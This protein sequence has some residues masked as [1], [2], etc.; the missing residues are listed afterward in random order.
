MKQLLA[1]SL[2]IASAL[3]PLGCATSKPAAGG[4]A[5]TGTISTREKIALPAGATVAVY[6]I[7]NTD[8]T[9]PA[10]VVTSTMFKPAGQLPVPFTLNYEPGHINPNS[11]YS[12]GA[13]VLVGNEVFLRAESQQM[14]ITKGA[15][16]S[17]I[18]LNLLRSK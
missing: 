3:L 5:V 9:A 12:V 15:P 17:G 8:I 1:I 4:A 13:R 14:V 10:E 16:T 11:R 7:E 6:L 2:I 18:Q